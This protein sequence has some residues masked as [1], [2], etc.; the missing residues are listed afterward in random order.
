MKDVILIDGERYRKCKYVD[1]CCENTFL[2][3]EVVEIMAVMPVYVSGCRDV[4]RIEFLMP[5]VKF[6]PGMKI[7]IIANEE[8]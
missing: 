6:N 1:G 2:E 4:L 8:E 7:R 3:G 5:K